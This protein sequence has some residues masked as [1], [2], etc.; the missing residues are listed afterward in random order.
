MDSV[1]A[2]FEAAQQRPPRF[3]KDAPKVE[4]TESQLRYA[5][6]VSRRIA[7]RY[8]NHAA[9]SRDDLFQAGVERIMHELTRK[10]D[11]RTSNGW[12]HKCAEFAIKRELRRLWGYQRPVTLS[13]PKFDDEESNEMEDW[14]LAV[15][16]ELDN[17]DWILAMLSE[18]ERQVALFSA[19]GYEP[20]EITDMLSLSSN[21]RVAAILKSAQKKLVDAGVR[22]YVP[23]KIEQ[24]VAEYKS[25]HDQQVAAG[26]HTNYTFKRD[27]SPR[28]AQRNITRMQLAQR[29]TRITR[30]LAR[31]GIDA[32]S[33]VPDM[34]RSG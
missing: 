15:E 13:A 14:A 18:Q 17:T 33:L 4:M 20:G 16:D 26:Y 10:P 8:C 12:M 31:H 19:M 23:T 25:I 11:L 24:W 2:A 34:S 7:H 6:A 9:V 21:S 1:A 3:V 32:K 30:S 28:D 27:G 5:M 29:K 22:M